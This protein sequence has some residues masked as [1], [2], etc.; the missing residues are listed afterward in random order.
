LAHYY[1]SDYGSRDGLLDAKWGYYLTE[2]RLAEAAA[3]GLKNVG[4]SIDGL[5]E[6]HDLLRGIAGSFDQAFSALRAARRQKLVTSVN[7]QIGPKTISQLR[8]LQQ[9]LFEVQVS[10]WQVQLTVAMGNAA[11]DPSLLLQPYQLIELMPLLSELHDEGIQHEMLLQPG[12]NIGYFGP[13]ERKWR[14][15]GDGSHFLGCTAGHTVIGIES[16]GVIKGC[17]VRHSA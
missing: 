2:K 3:V 4:I 14:R 10:N 1:S 15:R 13:Y 9:K 5:A 7:T 6:L 12:N 17:P 11:D 16:D 8:E